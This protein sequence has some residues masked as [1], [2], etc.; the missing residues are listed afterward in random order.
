[1]DGE[2]FPVEGGY[3][4]PST[5]TDR[6][7]FIVIDGFID[8]WDLAFDVQATLTDVPAGVDLKLE[9]WHMETD[10]DPTEPGAG[11]V[12]EANAGGPG[13]D[14]EVSIG[15]IVSEV[16]GLFDNAGGLYEVRVTSVDGTSSCLAPYTLT[17]DADTR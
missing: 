12:G 6:Y 9:L 15:G 4:Y 14:E 2:S 16:F 3:L 8:G 10:A 17:I 7:S 1:M 5:D 13:E 11:M